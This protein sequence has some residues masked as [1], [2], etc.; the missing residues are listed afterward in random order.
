MLEDKLKSTDW[1]ATFN[2]IEEAVARESYLLWLKEQEN[3]YQL[4]EKGEVI[5]T[6]VRKVKKFTLYSPS[7]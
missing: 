3:Q 5:T 6:N 7:V 1:D 4:K 2:S